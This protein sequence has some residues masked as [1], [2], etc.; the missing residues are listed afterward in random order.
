MRQF[1][2]GVGG[3]K[4]MDILTVDPKSERQVIAKGIVRF[5]LYPDR[6]DWTFTDVSGVVRDQGSQATRLTG[7]IA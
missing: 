7:A 1:I 6:Y 3:V 2:T 5:D 4:S